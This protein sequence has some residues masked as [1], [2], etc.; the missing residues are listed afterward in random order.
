MTS[1]NPYHDGEQWVQR[2]VGEQEIANRNG[3]VIHSGMLVNAIPFVEQQPFVVLSYL[4]N[5]EYPLVS[6][7]SGKPGFMK[8][9]E[10]LL[11]M[12]RSKMKLNKFDPVW[13]HLSEGALTGF[14]WIDL[15]SR[16]R[17][18]AS[19]NVYAIDAQQLQFGIDLSYPNCPKYIQRRVPSFVEQNLYSPDQ[20]F[21]SGKILGEEQRMLLNQ[22]DTVFV[23][24]YYKDSGVDASHRG[25]KPGFIKILNKQS[26]RF[27]DYSGNSMYNTLGN[28]V[29]NPLAGLIVPDFQSGATLQLTGQV[30]IHWS[31][32][33]EDLPTGGT[34]RYWDFHIEHW[35]HINNAI[36]FQWEFLD[37]SPF[38]PASES[39]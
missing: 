32:D 9:D 33:N 26:L 22:A 10:Q 17:L 24:S 34:G 27:P 29:R 13:N 18:R 30:E 20:S 36:P 31:L 12:D 8:S 39:L 7:L 28:F 35:T 14:L 19:G 3:R 15:A 6:I 4:N 21:Q 5:E 37:Y 25:G 11:R 23:G 2:K 16:R 38:H 1:N